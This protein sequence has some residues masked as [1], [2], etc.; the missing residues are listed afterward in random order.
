[1]QELMKRNHKNFVSVKVD[2][3][4]LFRLPRPLAMRFSAVWNA[5]LKDITRTIVTVV[6]PLDPPA[7]PSPQATQAVPIAGREPAF[8]SLVPPPPPPPSG[9][10]AL[11]FII[12]WME[13][14]GCEPR[15]I[16]AIPY[17]SDYRPAL[18]KILA[19]A[20]N[21][22]INELVTRV[23]N[24]LGMRAPKPKKCPT[25]KKLEH[26]GKECQ[27]CFHCGDYNHRIRDCPVRYEEFLEREARRARKA[28][29][30]KQREIAHQR[31][32]EKEERRKKRGIATGEL[33]VDDAG[34]TIPVRGPGTLTLGRT[35]SGP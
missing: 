3:E 17:P 7:A 34:R 13:A 22:E 24:D 18:E 25:C 31:W 35:T 12:Q 19:V 9:K 6:L 26:P 15:G 16:Q 5:A 33:G 29:W 1:M 11:K 4:I 2:E 28:E 30:A 32:L 8:P 21:L 23:K 14:G 20:S 10:T 27:S